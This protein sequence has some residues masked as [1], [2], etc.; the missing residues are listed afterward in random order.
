[1]AGSDAM[2]AQPLGPGIDL[3]VLF[4]SMLELA[5]YHELVYDQ[6][7]SACDYRI[8]ACNDAFT[9]VTGI[10]RE[11]AVGK[12][13]S[14]VYGTRAPYLEIYARV[15]ETGEPTRFDAHF[16]PLDRHFSISVV[17]PA[18]GIFATISTDATEHKRAVEALRRY[19]LLSEY[20]QDI[21]LFVQAEDGRVVDANQAAAA[22]YGY[23]RDELRNLTVFDLR[24]EATHGATAAQMAWAGE[25]GSRF[26]TTHR[27]KD[28]TTFPVEVSS[29][30]AT[31]G[32]RRILMSLIRDI[33]IRKAAEETL[34]SSEA[35]L[36]AFVEQS[37]AAMAMFDRRMRYLAASRRYVA[38]Y[39]LK[40]ADLVG[41]SHYDVF[42]EIPDRWKEIHQRCLSGAID[43][44]SVV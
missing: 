30:G 11:K 33:T 13:A 9:R 26:E 10:P 24:N 22:A 18:K 15:V 4:D 36:R 27:R 38:D 17:S 42:P 31:T 32:D 39:R 16:A 23:T 44:K 1:M 20:T 29:I 25:H 35:R 21:V 43:R 2:S 34:R 14:E 3:G 7:G 40:L 28:G 37:P 6:D 41:R 5:V 19:E 8:L 12:L